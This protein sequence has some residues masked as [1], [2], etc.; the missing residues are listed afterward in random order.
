MIEFSVLIPLERNSDRKE[1]C[2]TAWDH[3]EGRLF[4]LFG[5]FTNCGEVLGVWADNHGNIVRD[6]SRHYI[7]A[8]EHGREESMWQLLRDSK[9]Q[10]DQVCIYASITSE[11]AHL[12]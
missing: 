8:V 1:H 7:V 4:D 2:F 3:F 11:H 12:V 9:A 5:G 10:F 6:K